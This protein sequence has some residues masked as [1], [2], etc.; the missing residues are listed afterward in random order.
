MNSCAGRGSAQADCLQS[1]NIINLD[2]RC[3]NVCIANGTSAYTCRQSCS[4]IKD[5]ALAPPQAPRTSIHSQFTAGIL[6]DPTVLAPPPPS[7]APTTTAKNQLSPTV[8]PL[9]PSTNF[10]CL[11]QCAQNG[12][13]F[14]YC[15][16][17]CTY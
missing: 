6:I 3:L 14:G 13:N 5:T 17:Q 4:Y 1:C 7:A 2:H 9:G 10:K 16:Q 15:R 11:S 12:L 8:Q